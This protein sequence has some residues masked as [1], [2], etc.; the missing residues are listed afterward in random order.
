MEYPTPENEKAA[1]LTYHMAPKEVWEAQKGSGSYLPESYARDGFVHTAHGLEDLLCVANDY[2]TGDR[3]DQTVLVIDT[4]KLTSPVRYDDP[5][6]IFPHIYG[7]INARAVVEE[8]EV[9]RDGEGRYLAFEERAPT[10]T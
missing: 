2:Y 1:G 8:L 7:P 3:R 4:S 5:R 10:G 6:Q 9:R